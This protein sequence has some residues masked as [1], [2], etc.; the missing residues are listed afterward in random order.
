VLGLIPFWSFLGVC[1]VERIYCSC[2]FGFPKPWVESFRVLLPPPS[3]SPRRSRFLFSSI[4]AAVVAADKSASLTMPVGHS[5]SK[6]RLEEVVKFS[7]Y[8]AQ[9]HLVEGVFLIFKFSQQSVGPGSAGPS[10]PHPA[11]PQSI[12]TK[13]RLRLAAPKHR[14]PQ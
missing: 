2:Q 1:M 12:E 3:A 9:D 8:F 10:F 6:G 11:F 4:E 13:I 14:V 5:A 7:F